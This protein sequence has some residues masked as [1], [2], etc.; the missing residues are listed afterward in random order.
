MSVGGGLLGTLFIVAISL[1]EPMRGG[2]RE[3]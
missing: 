3:E 2:G 1:A